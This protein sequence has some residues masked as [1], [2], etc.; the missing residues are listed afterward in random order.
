MKKFLAVAASVVL[1]ATIVAA[2]TSTRGYPIPDR[3]DETSMRRY[4]ERIVEVVKA[5]DTDV[6]SVEAAGASNA[7]L[8]IETNRAQ[9]AE[10]LLLP[11]ASTNAW[12]IAAFEEWVLQEST[13][14]WNIAA[15][16]SWVLQ[17]STASWDIATSV[18]PADTSSWDIATSVKPA[19][20]ASWDIATSVKPADTS[21]WDIATSVKPADVIGSVAMSVAFNNVTNGVL[22]MQLK[23]EAGANPG[24]M[25]LVNTWM[26]PV[27]ST[28]VVE[29]QEMDVASSIT[30]GTAVGSTA[31][32]EIWN[33]LTDHDGK[34]SWAFIST[35]LTFTNTAYCSMG[36]VVLGTVD[37]RVPAP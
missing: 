21:S 19:S 20:T 16:E 13:S 3:R 25:Y 29:S 9:V 11:I 15:F 35:N 28:G 5:I 32:N 18:K 26:G 22:S 2:E 17:A 4:N 1:I 14:S 31:T 37:I 10:A 36:G 27:G 33:V 8:I 30:C 7:D 23:T 12:N 24:A 34:V 6:T